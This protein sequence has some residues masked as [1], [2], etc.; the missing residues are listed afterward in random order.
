MTI[1]ESERLFLRSLSIDELMNIENN[2][3]GLLE[4][5][6]LPEALSDIVLSAITKK[7]EKMK[8][9]EEKFYDLYTYWLIVDKK[10]GNG[11]GFAGFKGINEDGLTDVG[12]SISP[13]H[14]KKGLMTE[15]LK[16]LLN[17]AAGNKSLRGITATVNKTNI[18]SIK[19]IRNCNFTLTG[20]SDNEYFYCFEFKN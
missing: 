3:A 8:D 16:A 1:L 11:I 10:S 14:R 19:V 20:S 4:T 5:G 7:I 12:Y 6:V 9:I 17:W 13:D 18:G 15:A 2:K